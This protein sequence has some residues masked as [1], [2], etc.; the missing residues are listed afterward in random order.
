M[1]FFFFFPSTNFFFKYSSESEQKKTGRHTAGY[2]FFLITIELGEG[3]KKRGR[4][5]ENMEGGEIKDHFTQ[6]IK[7]TTAQCKLCDS[8]SMHTVT[9]NENSDIPSR[10]N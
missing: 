6:L 5:I 10:G 9:I 7:T 1:V 4:G 2:G 3:E 8:T